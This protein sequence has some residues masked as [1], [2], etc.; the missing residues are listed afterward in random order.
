VM[1]FKGNDNKLAGIKNQ[2]K[3]PNCFQQIENTSLMI[4]W[5]IF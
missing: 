5:E 3:W 1:D 4:N 2:S